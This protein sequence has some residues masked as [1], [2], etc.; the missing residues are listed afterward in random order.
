MHAQA[1]TFGIAFTLAITAASVTAVRSQT[2]P[3][4]YDFTVAP[5]MRGTLIPSSETAPRLTLSQP[6]TPY[7]FAVV[8]LMRG[9]LIPSSEQGLTRMRT[10]LAVARS[11]YLAVRVAEYRMDIF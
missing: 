11:D 5:P 3:R 7:D 6:A 8:P 10:E 9:T 4:G 2:R 1:L